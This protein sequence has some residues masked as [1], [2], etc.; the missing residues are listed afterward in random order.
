M[1]GVD[2]INFYTNTKGDFET[3]TYRKGKLQ[4]NIIRRLKIRHGR[5]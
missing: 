4:E 3:K 5:G 2:E 1:W